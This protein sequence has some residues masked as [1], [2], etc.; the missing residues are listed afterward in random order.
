MLLYARNEAQGARELYA[1]SDPLFRH[2]KSSNKEPEKK[3]IQQRCALTASLLIL[4]G[5]GW[6]GRRPEEKHELALLGCSLVAGRSDAVGCCMMMTGASC[7]ERE[8][9]Y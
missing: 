8:R 3:K 1:K 6:L 7:C 4:P 9:S 5:G 2:P